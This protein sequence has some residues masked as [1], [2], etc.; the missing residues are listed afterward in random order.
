MKFSSSRY[1]TNKVGFPPQKE[2]YKHRK[3]IILHV[4]TYVSGVDIRNAN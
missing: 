1:K 3:E 2:H 4:L